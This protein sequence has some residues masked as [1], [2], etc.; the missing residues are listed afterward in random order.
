VI[1]PEFSQPWRW[2]RTSDDHVFYRCGACGSTLDWRDHELHLR[3]HGI[4]NSN[5]LAELIRAQEEYVGLVKPRL[6]G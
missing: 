2:F 1:N 6:T 5:T 4:T 3:W